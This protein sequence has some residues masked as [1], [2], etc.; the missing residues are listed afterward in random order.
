M[1]LR[2]CF[3]WSPSWITVKG[4]IIYPHHK[5]AL[6]DPRHVY[7][8]GY[9]PERNYFVFLAAYSPTWAQA[10]FRL[11]FQ[12]LMFGCWSS[13]SQDEPLFQY[14]PAVHKHKHYLQLRSSE[15]S[16]WSSESRRRLIHSAAEAPAAFSVLLL[17]P[18]F[19]FLLFTE[20]SCFEKYIIIVNI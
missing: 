11:A 6:I 14:D 8:E 5:G 17:L 4:T 9:S 19:T 12:N 20:F 15:R 13:K 16:L 2:C 3:A 1:I 10:S 18:A 7:R